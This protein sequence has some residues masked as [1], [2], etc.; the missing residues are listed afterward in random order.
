V[1]YSFAGGTDGRAPLAP[2]IQDSAGNLYGTAQYGGD[3]DAGLVFKVDAAGNKTTLYSFTGGAGGGLPVAGLAQDAEGNLYGTTQY[4]GTAKGRSGYGVVFK[5]DTAGNE[6]V[7]H[8]F[9]G[10]E[11]GSQPVAGL[12][13]DPIGNLY[14]TTTG[15]G[16]A[17]STCPNGCGVAF[18]IAP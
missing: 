9:T 11:D 13:R 8:T 16:V 14:G 6:T 1:L 18:K 2:L 7:L 4:G 10:G 12:L 17:N 15:G 5:L 3:F